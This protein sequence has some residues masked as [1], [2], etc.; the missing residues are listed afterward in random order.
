[1]VMN[2]FITLL[3]RTAIAD[4]T[5]NHGSLADEAPEEENEVEEEEQEEQEEEEEEGKMEDSGIIG[6]HSTDTQ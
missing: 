5:A 6:H 2:G 1:M 3:G 4:T